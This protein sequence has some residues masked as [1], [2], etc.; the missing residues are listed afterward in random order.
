MSSVPAPAAGDPPVAPATAATVQTATAAAAAAAEEENGTVAVLSRTESVCPRCLRRLP[1]ERLV[2][3][4][5]VYLRRTCPEHGTFRTIVWRGEPSHRTWRR[6]KIPAA[7]ERPAT[8]VSRGC[9]F[10]CGLCPDH[11]QAA[12]CVLIELTRRCDLHC[13]VCFADAGGRAVGGPGADP[14]LGTVRE[15][16]RRLA[17][18]AGP[19]N[20]QLSGGEPTVRDDL[21]EII[22]AGRDLG[23][24]YLQ[25]NTNGLRLARDP[26]YL[27]RLVTAGLSTVFLQFDSLDE[28]ANRRL[29]GRAVAAHKREA[30][31]RCAQEGVGVVLVPT[32]IPG[33]NVDDLG[34]LLDYALAQVPTVRGMHV[35][36][37]SYFGRYPGPPGDANRLTL[38]EAMRALVRA[39]RGRI[40]LSA[41]SPPGAEHT[42]CS[43]HAHFVVQP[44]GTLTPLTRNPAAGGCCPSPVPARQG[45]V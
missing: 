17:E 5:D 18:T 19:V 42:W 15:W 43:F 35:Q 29:R 24:G 33:V 3:G 26:D 30:V 12:C 11:R 44:E 23:F 13:P 36:P 25:L 10:D 41:F 1:A 32:L 7:P 4:P 39:G 34:P 14:P 28:T 31:R 45:A 8:A 2:R 21:P 9:P 27:H 38:P 20:V 16:L 37:V 40:P 6:P 22:R